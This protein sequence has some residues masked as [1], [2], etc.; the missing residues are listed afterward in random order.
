MEFNKDSGSSVAD[1]GLAA[2]GELEETVGSLKL[3]AMESEEGCINTQPSLEDVDKLCEIE[4]Q[5]KAK[6]S[7]QKQWGPILPLRRSSK[8][9]DTGKTML[10]KAQ[11]AKRKWNLENKAGNTKISKTL[12]VNVANEIDVEILDGNPN[13]V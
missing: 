9:L 6:R 11:E 4:D 1:K 3:S 7:K 2:I 10:E 5:A 12:L 8:N 13:V